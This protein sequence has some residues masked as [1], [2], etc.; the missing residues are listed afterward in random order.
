L[1]KAVFDVVVIGAG[2]AGLFCAA[3]AARRGRRVLVLDHA[4]EP[5][6]KIL[7]S[8]GGRCNFTNLAVKAENFLSA[9]P[10]FAKSALAKFSSQDFI[11]LV[12]AHGIA[13]HEKRLGQLFCD[14]S[15][16]S[17]LGMLLGL[18]H[19]NNVTLRM[20]QK[21][22]EISRGSA[23]TLKTSDD[24][25]EATSLVLAT[26]GLSIPK[27]GATGFTYDIARQFGLAVT[28]VKPGL[29]PLRFEGAPWDWMQG[30]SGVSFESVARFGKREFREHSLFTHRGLSGPA[31]LQISSYL[32]ESPEA[33]ELTLN[34]L[35]GADATALLLERKTARPKAELKTILAEIFPAR[36]AQALLP[37]AQ[38]KQIIAET[39]NKQL[40]ELGERV[41]SLRL[42][43]TGTEG[44]AKAEVTV[45]GVDTTGLSSQTM[46]ATNVPGLFVIGEA[47]DVTGW[48]GGYNFQWAWSSGFAAGEAA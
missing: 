11:K 37:E 12:E 43:P 15:A 13:Y 26:G 44:F 1:A 21:V 47:V 9:N 10:H 35:P 34:M 19:Q 46:G 8:G 42:C 48:L 25:V 40:K 7:I 22:T 2:A 23:F 39:S 6:A 18:C 31:M 3:I 16:R 41:N 32:S 4:A 33:G 17:I 20:S 5:G 38:Q 30:L 36:L 24:L 45:G 14:D 28:P 29:V 27:L